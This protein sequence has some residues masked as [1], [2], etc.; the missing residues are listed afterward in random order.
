MKQGGG[1]ARGLSEGER[2]KDKGQRPGRR[3]R[4]RGRSREGLVHPTH[5]TSRPLLPC[6]AG[7]VLSLRV[8]VP[9]QEVVMSLRFRVWLGLTHSHSRGPVG[10]LTSW[11]LL[12]KSRAWAKAGLGAAP[13]W[14][15][16]PAGPTPECPSPHSQKEAGC[17]GPGQGRRAW[18]S[19]V[20][21]NRLPEGR[22][23]SSEH[24]IFQ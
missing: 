9:F 21:W 16:S 20:W 24:R 3:G 5:P 2:W 7:A 13:C 18:P 12:K 1:G 22:A 4:G 11:R 8:S 10:L 15:P 14:G 6:S 19:R 17:V 23:C